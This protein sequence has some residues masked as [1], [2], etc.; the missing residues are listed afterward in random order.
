MVGYKG[1]LLLTG[2]VARAVRQRVRLPHTDRP[3]VYRPIHRRGA[4]TEGGVVRGQGLQ[5]LLV[6]NGGL[7]ATQVRLVGERETAGALRQV[8]Q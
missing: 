4:Y 3:L 5:V 6:A 1:R 7:G 8:V 2:V